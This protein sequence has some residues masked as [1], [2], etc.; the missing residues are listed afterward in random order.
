MKIT[1]LYDN[2]AIREELKADWGFACLIETDEHTILFDTGANGVILLNN[3]DRLDVKPD[4]IDMIFISH[5]HFDHTGGLSAFLNENKNVTIYV[6]KSL[7][8]IRNVKEIVYIDEPR[9]LFPHIYTT[10][11][12]AN[13]EQSLIIQTDKGCVIIAGCSHPDMN[14]ILNASRAFGK[15]Y[16][17]IGGLHGFN[18]FDLFNELS[19][20]CPTHCTK[21]KEQIHTTYPDKYIDGGVGKI[22]E[23]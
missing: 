18:Q 13:I 7:R 4:E 14:L 23:I 12:L 3:M 15:L 9:M 21:Y 5:N 19:L 10:G 1:I 17:I 20:V 2:T 8:G 11:E 22:I 6:P 16:A